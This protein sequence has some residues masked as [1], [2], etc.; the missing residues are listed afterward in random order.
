MTRGVWPFG[1]S[2]GERVA[3]TPVR[4]TL[5]GKN[6]SVFCHFIMKCSIIV[7]LVLMGRLS[8]RFIS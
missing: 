6:G 5:D 4:G 3:R 2:H 8:M 7:L 1:L